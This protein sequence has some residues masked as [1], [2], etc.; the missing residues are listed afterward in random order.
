MYRWA[1]KYWFNDFHAYSKVTPSAAN[2]AKEL[3]KRLTEKSVQ[4]PV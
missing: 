4:V 3:Q 1:K 2:K